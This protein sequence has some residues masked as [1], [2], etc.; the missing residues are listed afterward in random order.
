MVFADREQTIS[1]GN[2]HGEYPAKVRT[3]IGL[4][5]DSLLENLW[6]LDLIPNLSHIYVY[7]RNTEPK[8]SESNKVCV[9][10]HQKIVVSHPMSNLS[11]SAS[12]Y[13][14][15]HWMWKNKKILSL[16]V[17][18]PITSDFFKLSEILVS[19]ESSYFSHY[20]W[21]ILQQKNE[22]SGRY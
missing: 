10:I 17:P 15:K 12:K 1:G 14:K 4:W 9:L 5:N 18:G 20:P 6:K 2:F 8:S 21:W 11:Q 16:K 22:P 13:V 7:I 19:E 3:E